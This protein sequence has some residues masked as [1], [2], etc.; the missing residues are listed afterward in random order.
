MRRMLPAPLALLLLI[1][2]SLGSALLLLR[3]NVNN[4]PEIY[5]L[6]LRRRYSSSRSC[7]S[8]FRTIR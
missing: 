8:G 6:P 4:A 2:L 5:F 1:A 3:L 7:A